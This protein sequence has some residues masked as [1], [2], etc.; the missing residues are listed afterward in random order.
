MDIELETIRMSPYQLWRNSAYRFIFS[1]QPG[2]VCYSQS[3]VAAKRTGI[4]QVWNEQ[5]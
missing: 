1:I 5:Q 2:P 4:V 3:L